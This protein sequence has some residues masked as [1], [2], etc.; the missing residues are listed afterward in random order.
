MSASTVFV[1]GSMMSISRLCVRIS[2]CSR[3]SLWTN[4]PRM[5]VYFSM[6]VGSGTGPAMSA[7]AW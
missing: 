1:D 3:P 7:P 5:T 6:R 4:G 2:N